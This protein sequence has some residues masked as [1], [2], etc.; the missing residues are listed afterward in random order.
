[1]GNPVAVILNAD[2]ISSDE[3]QRIARWTNLSE[4]TFILQP[5]HADADYKLRIF[6]ASRELPFAGH[7]SLG[8]CCAWLH[9]GGVPKGREYVIQECGIGLI[10]LSQG[11]GPNMLA[12]E[13]PEPFRMGPLDEADVELVAKGL[14]IQRSDI[15]RHSWCDNGPKWRGIMLRSMED[16]LA[17]KPNDACLLGMDVGIIGPVVNNTT[18]DFGYEVRAFCDEGGVIVEDPV[19]GSLNAALAQWLMR[20]GVIPRNYV[21]RQG[22]VIDRNGRVELS[23]NDDN[24][25]WVG[26]LARVCIDGTI[27]L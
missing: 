18:L 26:G 6:T 8:S 12:F 11:P 15:I 1:M 14:G 19:T 4:T 16:V 10:K 22:T 25:V 5:E 20:E 13:A 24:K 27:A 17:V 9:N 7:P 23:M 3:M 2:D 21:S